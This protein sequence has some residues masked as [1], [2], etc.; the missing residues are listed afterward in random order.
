MNIPDF[1]KYSLALFEGEHI[2]FE[3][4]ESRLKPLVEMVQIYQ[5]QHTDCTL[6]DKVVGLASAKIISA[7]GMISKLN[8]G[9]MSKDARDFLKPTE[10]Q[11]TY[12]MLVDEIQNREKD[13]PCKME[14]KA[15][16]IADPDEF[17]KAMIELMGV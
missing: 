14:G 13:G 7:S 15:R 6:H 10:V 2:L 17:L 3:S 12:Q 9:I 1:K 5:G 11:Y 8:A 4:N 16:E